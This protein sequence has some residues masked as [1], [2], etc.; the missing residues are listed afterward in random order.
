MDAVEQFLNKK[1]S[2][3]AEYIEIIED[4]MAQYPAYNYA[5]DTLMGILRYA[6]RNNAITDNQIK[7]VE[8]I[9]SEPGGAYEH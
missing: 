7:A 9:R 8:N 6:Q 5:E 1:A 2:K 3:A 4:M